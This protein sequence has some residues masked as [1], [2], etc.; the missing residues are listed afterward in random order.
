[1]NHVYEHPVLDLGEWSQQRQVMYVAR[2]HSAV[3]VVLTPSTTL[4]A[5]VEHNT[6]KGVQLQNIKTAPTAWTWSYDT[7]SDGIRADV[8]Y[9]IC[10]YRH[11]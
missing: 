6:A 8:S 4:D 9:D 7:I 11:H 1:M 10:A 2:L 5:N 3:E